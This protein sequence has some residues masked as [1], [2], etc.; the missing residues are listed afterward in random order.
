MNSPEIAGTK[1]PLVTWWPLIFTVFI[2]LVF[3]GPFFRHAS[4]REW[5]LVTLGVVA[6]LFLY[7]L[8]LVH[9]RK[10][11]IVLWLLAGEAMLG[12]IYAPFNEGAA[13]YIIYAATFVPF[14]V[15]GN[16]FLSISTIGAILSIVGLES[17]ILHLPWYFWV[18]SFAYSLIIGVGN[19]FSARQA[20]ASERLAK[21]E[22][23]ERIARDLHDILGHTLSLIVL[24]SEL[25]GKLL[26]LDPVRARAEI[27]D[28][29]RVSRAALADVRQ[30][31]SGYRAENL[32]DA[33]DRARSTLETAG[34]SFEARSEKTRI[35]PAQ[36]GV[37]AL[38]LR[39]A[40]TKIIRHAGA[41]KCRL[42]LKELDGACCLEIH[43]DGRGGEHSEGFGM[44]GM[45][46]RIEALGGEFRQEAGPGTRLIIT[47]PISSSTGADHE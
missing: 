24:K 15:E 13:L 22:E 47:I 5:A 33:F 11:R 23:R 36:E 21:M 26:D 1:R 7:C 43:D 10:K 35:T 27:G 6:F 18:Y 8:G 12:F 45:R 19:I 41:K 16:I 28:V 30:A 42:E 32:R 3:V 39:E 40:V 9:W 46:E 25:A 31:I 44:K 20:M 2:G 17:W 29:E 4:G 14:A 38:V 37:L 34:I